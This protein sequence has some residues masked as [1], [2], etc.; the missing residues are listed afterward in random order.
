MHPVQLDNSRFQQQISRKLDLSAS[1][2]KSWD[3]LVKKANRLGKTIYDLLCEIEQVMSYN[4][5]RDIFADLTGLPTADKVEGSIDAVDLRVIRTADGKAYIWHPSAAGKVLDSSSCGGGIYLISKKLFESVSG[6]GDLQ[7][8]EDSAHVRENFMKIVRDAVMSGA[9]DI[10]FFYHARNDLYKL[11]YR[12]LGDLCDISSYKV[13]YGRAVC[14]T[15]ITLTKE[16]TQSL[17]ID[18]VKRPQDGRIVIDESGLELDLRVSF[19]PISNMRDYDIAIRILKKEILDEVTLGSLGFGSR[20]VNTLKSLADRTRG[21]V[22]VT[23][24]TGSGKSKTV[25]TILSMVSPM[26]NVLTIEDPIEYSLSNGRQFQILEWK[27]PES[28][29]VMKTSFSEFSRAFKRHDP[30]VIFIGEVRD[31][32][33]VETAMHLSKTGHLVFG[34]LHVSRATMIPEIL[35]NDYGIDINSVADNLIL[36]VNQVLVKKLCDC[37]ERDEVPETLD[38]WTKLLR[39]PNRQELLQRLSGRARY[40]P[41]EKGCPRCTIMKGNK[42]LSVGYQG[43]TVVAEVF[44]FKPED[45]TDGTIASFDFERRFSEQRNLLSDAVDKIEAGIIDADQM[46]RFL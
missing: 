23:G 31:K 11:R 27:N 18:E 6:G 13:A 21:I 2:I 37:K 43:R 29:D 28:H 3:D 25:N 46:R 5:L 35:V 1:D 17:Q 44:E 33:T 24:S 9:T 36:G 4:D 14:H 8:D 45:F 26:R 40:F 12:V 20:H 41:S 16:S 38:D 32:E 22:L 39:F 34:T 42:K 7:I 30:D 10:H 19:L 15:I